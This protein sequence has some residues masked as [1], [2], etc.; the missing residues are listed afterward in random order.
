MAKNV[1]VSGVLICLYSKQ[2]VHYKISHMYCKPLA[3]SKGIF[4]TFDIRVLPANIQIN[5]S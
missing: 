3:M 4:C 1:Y 2:A 5:G